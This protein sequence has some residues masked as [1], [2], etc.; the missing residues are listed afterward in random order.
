MKFKNFFYSFFLICFLA[1]CTSPIVDT[2][3]CDKFKK[4]S[5]EYVG[6]VNSIISSTNAAKNMNEFKKHKTIKSFL[7]QVEVIESN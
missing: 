4:T 1:G 3:N 6:C 2:S 7:K 5:K